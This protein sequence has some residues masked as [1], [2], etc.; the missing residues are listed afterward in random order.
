[1]GQVAQPA[2]V[3]LHYGINHKCR[4]LPQVAMAQ[5][6][7]LSA[8]LWQA[9]MPLSLPLKIP[10]QS[11][12]QGLKSGV[13]T[14]QSTTLT[15][16]DSWPPSSYWPL[17]CVAPHKHR[18]QTVAANHRALPTSSY[19]GGLSPSLK[20][21]TH[22]ARAGSCSLSKYLLIIPCSAPL[23]AEL[24][25]VDPVKTDQWLIVC[26]SA[27]GKVTPGFGLVDCFHLNP[28]RQ[29]GSAT[30]LRHILIHLKYSGFACV[31]AGVT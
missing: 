29:A 21:D 20:Q 4:Q 30:Y 10:L 11:V 5:C 6:P 28:P 9:A 15:S 17:P 3:Y 16:P 19:G 25:P 13:V 26:G 24:E 27:K 14:P 2:P 22:L 23:L 31:H 12:H 8:S 1:M 7:W 18:L